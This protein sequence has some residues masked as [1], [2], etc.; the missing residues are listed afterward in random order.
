MHDHESVED[1]VI[2]VSM[3]WNG[4]PSKRTK[5]TK[6]KRQNQTRNGKDFAKLVAVIEEYLLVANLNPSDGPGKEWPNSILIEDC[7][8]Q[9]G[10]QSMTQ[11]I[12]VQLTETYVKTLNADPRP[13]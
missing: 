4:E 8:D 5:K 2:N 3:V 6:L 11:P 9:M 13:L 7:E 1:I 12:C 10:P